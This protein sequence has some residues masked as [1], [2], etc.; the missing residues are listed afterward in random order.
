MHRRSL[1]ILAVT[2]FLASASGLTLAAH[3]SLEG[4]HHDLKGCAVCQD[5]LAGSI[6]V[7]A[8][9]TSI[10]APAAVDA[11]IAAPAAQQPAVPTLPPAIA[12]R[13]PPLA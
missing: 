7:V 12:P 8:V 10:P 11:I 6:A 13:G 5:L 2:F 3:E 4:P 1:R 9:A